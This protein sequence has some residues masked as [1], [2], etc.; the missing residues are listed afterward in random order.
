[1]NI[2]TVNLVFSTLVFWLAAR[3]YIFPKLGNW[4]LGP[5]C[6]RFFCSTHFGTP[7]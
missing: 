7:G 6:C 5:F 3:I 2:L 1:M 4:S